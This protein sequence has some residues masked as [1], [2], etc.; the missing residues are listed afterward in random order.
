MRRLR[1]PARYHVVAAAG[2]FDC[3]TAAG[4]IARVL[5][6]GDPRRSLLAAAVV[7]YAFSR[8]LWTIVEVRGVSGE[9]TV[10]L[11]AMG[12]SRMKKPFSTV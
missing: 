11:G 1:D 5:G 4:A 3:Q 9:C 7:A 6:N 10:Q 8:R 12:A 2:L